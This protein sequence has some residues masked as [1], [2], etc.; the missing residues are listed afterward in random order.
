MSKRRNNRTV[1]THINGFEGNV[2]KP[3]MKGK[4]KVRSVLP[5]DIEK[6]NNDISE[7]RSII[8][9]DRNFKTLPVLFEKILRSKQYELKDLLYAV[10]KGYGYDAAYADGYIYAKG[11]IPVMLCAH[12]DTV[13]DKSVS[14][15]WMSDTGCVWSPQ[16]IGG[17]DRCGIYAILMNITE[18]YKPY[19]LF[20]ENEEIGCIG[21]EQFADDVKG[22]K[23]DE[24]SI[25]INCIIELDRKGS[26]DSVFYNCDNPEFEKYINS[27]GFKTSHGSCSDI[28]YIA[29][30][31]GIAAVNLSC[32]YYNQHTLNETINLDELYTTIDRV[33]KIIDDTAVN[34]TKVFEYIQA[35]THMNDFDWFYRNYKE[36]RDLEMIERKGCA[37]EGGD[38]SGSVFSSTYVSPVDFDNGAYIIDS[39]GEITNDYYDEI[40][41]D[42]NGKLYRDIS[43]YIDEYYT[44][45]ES[46]DGVAY[47]STGTLYKYSDDDSMC[48]LVEEG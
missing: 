13:H 34:G 41:I 18:K 15:I 1:K 20:T 26:D 16:G 5:P 9:K 24:N 48:V 17:D 45:V 37:D 4:G 7:Y 6:M 36:Q 22:G 40:F 3:K 21:A 8:N 19:I 27:F 38:I 23:I 44:V 43:W 11:N 35:V 28:S 2:T 25:E 46:I 42:E 32:G 39:S 12:M 29:P 30:A 10:L 33:G 14:T 47:N 31:L